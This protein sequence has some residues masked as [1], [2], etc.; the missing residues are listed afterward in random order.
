[1]AKKTVTKSIR[2]SPDEARELERLVQLFP[3]S[4]EANLIKAAYLRG[5][6]SLK[7]QGAIHTYAERQFSVGEVAEMYGLSPADLTNELV[8]RGIKLMEGITPAEA[9]ANIERL[10]A[11]TVKGSG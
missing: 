6:T 11:I 3:A 8:R 4:S 7:L 2:L 1:M 9:E 10:L 5:L